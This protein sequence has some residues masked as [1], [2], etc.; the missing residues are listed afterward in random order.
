MILSKLHTVKWFQFWNSEEY[1]VFIAITLD[2]KKT[3]LIDS[4]LFQSMGQIDFLIIYSQSTQWMV[5]TIRKKS[6]IVAENLLYPLFARYR[7]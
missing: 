7:E 1:G 5:W 6:R 4:I 2:K 3:G